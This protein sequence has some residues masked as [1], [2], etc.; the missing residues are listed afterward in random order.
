M[1]KIYDFEE[2]SWR[3]DRITSEE[4]DHLKDLIRQAKAHDVEAKQDEA[5]LIEL[6]RGEAKDMIEELQLRLEEFRQ[7]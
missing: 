1:S 2:A 7:R 5:D 6:S 4:V 3:D